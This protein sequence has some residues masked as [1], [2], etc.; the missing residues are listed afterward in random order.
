MTTPNRSIERPP[1]R[2]ALTALLLGLAASAAVLG[3]FLGATPAG[4]KGGPREL[5]EVDWSRDFE[6]GIASAKQSERP[7][8]LLFQEVPGCATCVG[9]GEGALSHPLLVETIETDFVP[10]AIYN[11]RGGEDAAVLERYGEPSWNNPVVRFVDGMGKDLI[12]RRDGVYHAR[13]LA[14]RMRAAL[15]AA[16]RPVPDHLDWLIEETRLD[17]RPHA[18]FVTHCFWEGEVCF[19]SDPAVRKT[20]ASWH[21]GR[22]VVEVWFDPE[23]SSYRDL[24]ARARARGCADAV[25][26]HDAEQAAIARSIFGDDVLAARGQPRKAPESDQ[27]R[28]LRASKLRHLTLTPLQATRINAALADRKDPRPWLSPRQRALLGL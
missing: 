2:P 24:V 23:H 15:A 25:V 19:G 22:E 27:K 1:R 12:P 10:V 9:F 26:S 13:S 7:V 4:A 20:R 17:A 8:F 28:H 18:T 6:A 11:N 5:G 14:P 21:Q 16:S 3:C